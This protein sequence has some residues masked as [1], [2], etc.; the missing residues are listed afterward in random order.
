MFAVIKAQGKQFRVA[1]GDTL[2]IDRLA[3]DAGATVALGE[4]LMLIDGGSTTIGAPVLSGAKVQAEIVS[5]SRGEK[6][7]VF[8]KRRRKNFHRTRGHRQELTT[9]KITAITA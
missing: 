2:V 8:K 4:V 5:H 6:I 7:K 1:Q 3:G 9:V